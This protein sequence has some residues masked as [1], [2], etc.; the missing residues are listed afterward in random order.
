MRSKKDL[1]RLHV[2]ISFGFEFSIKLSELEQVRSMIA[3]NW[4][5]LHQG[6][7]AT[8]CIN[9]R[10]YENFAPIKVKHNEPHNVI[11]R[12]T[13]HRDLLLILAFLLTHKS[14]QRR[15]FCKLTGDAIWLMALF[16]QCTPKRRHI[17]QQ[18][19]MPQTALRRES[20][21]T[22][23]KWSGTQGAGRGGFLFS[24][25]FVYIYLFIH[26]TERLTDSFFE[27][28]SNW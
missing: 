8:M 1:L 13:W 25:P 4:A 18:T 14:L 23:E 27:T 12:M 5:W 11:I 3:T 21:Y 26:I 24:S 2:T 20:N 19:N 22:N 7:I 6:Y 10:K 9:N 15:L 17:V 28:K 16:F